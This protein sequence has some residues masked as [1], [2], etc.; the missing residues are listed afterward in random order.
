MREQNG[1]I[2]LLYKGIAGTEV[3]IGQAEMNIT[4]GGDPI[5][6]SSKSDDGW[7][8]LLDDEITAQQVNINGTV[9]YN[10]DS[11]YEAVKSDAETGQHDYY[12]F[13][14]G[15]TNDEV[16]GVFIP[17]GMSD[18]FPGGDKVATT[19]TFN[20]SDAVM[21]GIAFAGVQIGRAIITG[22]TVWVD[23]HGKPS[24][25]LLPQGSAF[26]GAT[27][28]L[29][30]V[31]YPSLVTPTLATPTGSPHPYKIVADYTGGV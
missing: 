19:I 17:T 25:D 21:A 28:P 16:A 12:T 22:E 29:L 24:F 6:I 1:T 8:S 5:D 30:A 20:S 23:S 10:N 27:Y 2:C 13:K 14:F 26:S 3:L 15:L 7:V 4:Y 18:S 11:T 31:I 9:V